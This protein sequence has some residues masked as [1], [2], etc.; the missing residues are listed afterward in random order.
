MNAPSSPRASLAAQ[1]A[2][3]NRPI[4]ITP[5]RPAVQ[6]PSD[7]PIT[8]KDM[9]VQFFS[10]SR[11]QSRVV[12]EMILVAY[13]LWVANDW[14]A[15]GFTDVEAFCDHAGIT[16]KYWD[17][18]TLLGERLQLLTVGE[19]QGL[20][21]AMLNSLARVHPSIWSEYAWVEE[22]KALQAREFAML[23]TQRN[24]EV[25]KSLTEPR[26][27]LTVRVPLSQHPVL[28]R[29][30]EALRRQERLGSIGEALTFALESVDRADLMADTLEEIKTQVSELQLL[31]DGMEE[32]SSEREARLETGKSVTGTVVKAQ[33]L[34]KR[35][36]KK[37][38]GVVDEVYEEE[39]QEPGSGET[40]SAV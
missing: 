32:S 4:S 12:G 24:E 26:C 20:S 22:A 38:S 14:P 23:V 6:P 34:L 16:A 31:Y 17:Q 10:L 28:E 13:R 21:L 36:E 33:T 29:R 35:M 11:Q 40:I 7:A 19:V 9:A 18:L 37:I 5:I 1:V 2:A 15:L 3:Q 30:L 8:L 39:I 27:A 25:N